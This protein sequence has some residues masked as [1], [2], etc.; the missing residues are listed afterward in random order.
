VAAADPL[1]V[2]AGEATSLLDGAESPVTVLVRRLAARTRSAV[3]TVGADG[4]FVAR[5]GDVT[6]VEGVSV[7]RVVD[8]TGAGDAFAGTLAGYLANGAAL[9]NAAKN[10]NAEAA[11]IVALHRAL[12]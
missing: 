1:I 3:L 9:V 11:R 6:H 8:T 10:A 5:G 2:N 4:A 12:R 7:R